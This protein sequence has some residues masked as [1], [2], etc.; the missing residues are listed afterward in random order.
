MGEVVDAQDAYYHDKTPYDPKDRKEDLM[1][2]YLLCMGEYNCPEA[3]Y[4]LKYKSN[5]FASMRD[6]AA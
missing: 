3:V 6:N 1:V 2:T 5:S 4:N